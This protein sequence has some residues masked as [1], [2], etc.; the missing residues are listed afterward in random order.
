MPKATWNGTLLAES[1]GTVVVEGNH[2]FPI[3][4]IR[5]AYFTESPAHSL[6][7]WKG[8]ASYFD[9]VVDGRT[10]AGAAWYYPSPS[11]AAADIKDMVA[12]WGG[13]QVEV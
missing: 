13:V 11:P 10:N 3:D 7:A 1:E 4:S 5:S 6:C 2:Y 12:F 8:L 9:V